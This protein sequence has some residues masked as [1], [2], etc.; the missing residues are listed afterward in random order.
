MAITVYPGKAV[1]A[2]FT[3][4]YAGPATKL[5]LWW[6]LIEPDGTTDAF[7]GG[8]EIAVPATAGLEVKDQPAD[9][10]PFGGNLATGSYSVR[11]KV[12]SGD[13]KTILAE[14]SAESID[15]VQSTATGLGVSFGVI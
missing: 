10:A 5:V 1:R 3:F 14:S 2:F 7:S 15:V 11:A 4:N 13:W 12:M 6:G 8:A 9:S